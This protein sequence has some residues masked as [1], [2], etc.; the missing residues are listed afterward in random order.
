MKSRNGDVK[1]AQ[2]VVIVVVV[3][4][5]VVV[6]AVTAVAVVVMAVGNGALARELV[7][8]RAFVPSK[9]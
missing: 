1:S 9:A 7:R 8:W 3:V 5:I 6:V 2:S 4:V